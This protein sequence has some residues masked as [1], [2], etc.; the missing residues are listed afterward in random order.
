MKLSVYYFPETLDCYTIVFHKPLINNRGINE[1]FYIASSQNGVGFYQH[2][3]SNK[4][5]D[6][7]SYKHLGKRV[8]FDSLDSTLQQWIK[9]DYYDTF[10]KEAIKR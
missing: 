1:Y 2:L 8:K 10:T 5:I 3:S 6:K 9:K 4:R 7:P